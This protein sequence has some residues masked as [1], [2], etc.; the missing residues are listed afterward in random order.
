MIDIG[1]VMAGEDFDVKFKL[2]YT[3]DSSHRSL[4]NTRIILESKLYTGETA[5][6]ILD[7]RMSDVNLQK[8]RGIYRSKGYI[9]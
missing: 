3:G 5:G 9:A 8:D 4:K 7:K 2:K 6:V 1:E